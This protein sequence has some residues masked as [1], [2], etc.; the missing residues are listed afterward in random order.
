MVEIYVLA[1]KILT[2]DDVKVVLAST[3]DQ[4]NDTLGWGPAVLNIFN[5]GVLVARGAVK[6]YRARSNPP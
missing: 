4:M 6:H 2:F 5:A 3:Y 1:G